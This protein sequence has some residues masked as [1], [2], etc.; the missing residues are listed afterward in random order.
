MAKYRV[1]ASVGVRRVRGRLA[2]LV[3]QEGG[4][5]HGGLPPD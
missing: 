5:R 4:S 2:A 1:R 3:G